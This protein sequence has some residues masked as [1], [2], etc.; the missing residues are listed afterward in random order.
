MRLILCSVAAL[1]AAAPALAADIETP[2]R[3]DS[4]TLYPGAALATRI[5]EIALPAG[6]S[7]LILR[8][9]PAGLDPAS[10]RASG[11]GEQAV[12]IG[13]VDLRKSPA[14]APDGA[15]EAQLKGLRAERDAAQV[16]VDAL[17]VK[18]SMTQVYAQSGPDK[19]GETGL[20]PEE[21]AKAWENVGGALA[22]TGEDL[23]VA[24]AAV[25]DVD[26]RIKNLEAAR[27]APTPRGATQDVAVEVE[28]TAAGKFTLSLSYR[29]AGA[30]WSPSYD[31]RLDSGGKGGVPKLQLIR[32]AIISQTS[33]ED[34]S[35]VAL[36]LAAFPYG[37][38]TA[39]PEPVPQVIVFDEPP[40]AMAV[41]GA[42]PAPMAKSPAPVAAMRS[43]AEAEGGQMP[44][45][46]QQAVIESASL[47]AGAYRAIFRAPGR[48]S[49]AAD[50]TSRTIA[51][52]SQAPAVELNWKIA[53]ALDPRA[54]LSAHFVNA[55]E[56]PLL[57]GPV[58][59]IL[60]GAMVGTGA[61]KLLAPGA[62]ADLGFGADESVKIVRAPVKRKENEP[63][64][65]GQTKTE[66]RE[67]KT[68]LRNLHGFPIRAT[69]IDQTPF[70]EN[71]AIAVELLAQT[72]EPSEKEPDGKRGLLVW[73]FDLAAG[74]SKDVTLAYRMKWPADRD[75]IT[76]N[77]P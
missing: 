38:G 21:W 53:P 46:R 29:V 43:H 70:S 63:N 48:V 17:S 6:S 11:A 5:A 74:A 3:V 45:P 2:S 20:K 69:L 42:M 41:G 10:L 71:S 76:R 72:T 13:A 66:T 31:A 15:V 4:V 54:Y 16:K 59:L 34:W 58:T 24:R 60:D 68:S 56:A 25:A 47:D 14:P 75:V 77:A 36:S 37:G 23:R 18:L 65:W 62:E 49:L 1:C 44:P 64:R 40:L 12:T 26:L 73:R 61:L 30:R 22:R 57:A 33:G 19:F 39:A 67:F 52:S 7:R 55:E 9:L 28:A 51:L 35:D 50:G 32:R 8:G 27:P